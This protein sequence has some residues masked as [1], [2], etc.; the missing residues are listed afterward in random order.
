MMRLGRPEY[1]AS[2]R[3]KKKPEETTAFEGTATEQ[4]EP[5]R[6]TLLNR[7]KMVWSQK[8]GNYD[9]ESEE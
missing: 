8:K 6:S 9:Q 1:P 4:P 2:T 7:M 3:Q 5:G